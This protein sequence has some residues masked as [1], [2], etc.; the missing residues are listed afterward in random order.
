MSAGAW[1]GVEDPLAAD[2][3]GLVLDVSAFL[4]V[5]V[6]SALM[7]APRSTAPA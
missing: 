4:L 7:P 1:F 3:V 6:A 5:I 2:T